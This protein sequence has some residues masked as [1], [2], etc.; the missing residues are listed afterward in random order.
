[1]SY[2]CSAAREARRAQFLLTLEDFAFFVDEFSLPIASG[3]LERLAAESVRYASIELTAVLAMAQGIGVCIS[4]YLY[5]VLPR[6][7][8][9][10]WSIAGVTLGLGMIGVAFENIEEMLVGRRH[11]RKTTVR[12]LHVLACTPILVER[13][14]T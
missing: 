7:T 3:E 5:S 10:L 14:S 2:K 13:C 12:T 9:L 4:L 8:V 6:R 1:M 11:W